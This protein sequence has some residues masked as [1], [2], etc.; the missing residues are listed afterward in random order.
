MRGFWTRQQ[1]AFFDVRVTHPKANVLT[2]KE[3]QRQLEKIEQEKKRQYATRVN[4]ID[5]GAFTPL[6]FSTA[7]MVG[8]ECELF[9]KA[10]AGRLVERNIDVNY[11]VVMR[12]LRNNVAF[13]ILRW[14]IASLRGCRVSYHRNRPPSFMTEYGLTVKRHFE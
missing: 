11:S 12:H 8:N 6:V 4:N 14:N 3:V 1:D 13:S 9:L 7:G 2:V 5:R 10:L